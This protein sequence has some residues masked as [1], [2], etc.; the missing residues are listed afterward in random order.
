MCETPPSLLLNTHMYMQSINYGT[1][2]LR[3]INI[4]N[5]IKKLKTG[6]GFSL[7]SPIRQLKTNTGPS[8][9]YK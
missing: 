3:K 5:K 1:V 9:I 2:K 7:I 4:S 8:F 6:K